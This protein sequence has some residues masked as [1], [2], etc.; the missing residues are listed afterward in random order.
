MED[1]L[2]IVK[3]DLGVY[4]LDI[5]EKNECTEKKFSKEH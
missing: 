3:T 2:N 1:A 5:M 4:L